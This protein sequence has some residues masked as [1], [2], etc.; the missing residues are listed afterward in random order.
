MEKTIVKVNDNERKKQFYVC[1]HDSIYVL[2]LHQ[3]ENLLM[4]YIRQVSEPKTTK[5]RTFLHTPQKNQRH[6]T[7]LSPLASW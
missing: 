4:I 6:R 5:T 2:G 7:S 1:R 3:G